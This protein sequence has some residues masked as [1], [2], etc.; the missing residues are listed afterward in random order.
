MSLCIDVLC[1]HPYLPGYVNPF[2]DIRLSSDIAS[3]SFTSSSFTF[4][5][6]LR[7]S[8]IARHCTPRDVLSR[9]TARRTSSPLLCVGVVGLRLLLMVGESFSVQPRWTDS[10]LGGRKFR[11]LKH[12][13]YTVH[14][15]MLL[16]HDLANRRSVGGGEVVPRFAS[17]RFVLPLLLCQQQGIIISLITLPLCQSFGHR[18]SVWVVGHLSCSSRIAMW[19]IRV[20][21]ETASPLLHRLLISYATARVLSMGFDPASWSRFIISPSPE[22]TGGRVSK[23]HFVLTCFVAIHIF[24]DTSIHSTTFDSPWTWWPRIEKPQAYTIHRPL[25]DVTRT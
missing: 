24:L 9:T 6:S 2:D 12:I 5:S 11:T 19:L 18:D 20:Q 15:Q 3:C 7:W 4:S 17:L 21:A 8:S 1:R 16:E 13:L 14:Y 25:P 23:C 10:K 22:R